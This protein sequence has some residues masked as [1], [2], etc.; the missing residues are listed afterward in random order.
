MEPGLSVYI[1][2][3]HQPTSLRVP[4][5]PH[6]KSHTNK[7]HTIQLHPSV[8]LEERPRLDKVLAKLRAET[9]QGSVIALQEVSRGW[10]GHL[11]TFFARAGYHFVHCTSCYLYLGASLVPTY[12]LHVSHHV[13]LCMYTNTCTKQNT[14][15][16]SRPASGY[17]GVGLA[18]PTAE[19]EAV[20]VEISRLADAKARPI[21]GVVWR[22]FV[23]FSARGL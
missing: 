5:P 12:Y 15:G 2:P 21:D 4:S 13:P 16:Y 14:A 18:W 17:M 10:A 8:H 9:A 11:H 20:S 3:S 6:T 19:V 1:N 23:C 22:I 7:Q